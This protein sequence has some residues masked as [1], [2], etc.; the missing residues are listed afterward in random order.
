VKIVIAGIHS[1]KTGIQTDTPISK[2]RFGVPG[3]TP[4]WRIPFPAKGLYECRFYGMRNIPNFYGEKI[5]A[6]PVREK[7]T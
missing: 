1:Q 3:P 7:T 4:L 2:N 6:A 5:T